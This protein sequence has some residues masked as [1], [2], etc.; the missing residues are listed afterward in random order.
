SRQT[1]APLPPKP[2][3]TATTAPTAATGSSGSQSS[4]SAARSQVPKSTELMQTVAANLGWGGSPM[5]LAEVPEAFWKTVSPEVHTQITEYLFEQD[6]DAN[7]YISAQ[8]QELHARRGTQ[9]HRTS[10]HVGLEA[11][12]GG[13]LVGGLLAEPRDAV[14]PPLSTSS[15]LAAYP[16]PTAS[17]AVATP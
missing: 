6:Y 17:S 1:L 11:P 2:T 15:A 3:S 7:K 9:L 14:S 12:N 5:R 16:P 8:L 4:S 13:R 10:V